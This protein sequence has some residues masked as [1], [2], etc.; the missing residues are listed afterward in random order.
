MEKNYVKINLYNF[1]ITF[2]THLLYCMYSILM[3]I[4]SYEE[5]VMKKTLKYSVMTFV[6]ALLF[7]FVSACNN[8]NA[9]T[10]AAANNN[11]VVKASYDR[12]AVE[13]TK[14]DFTLAQSKVKEK[15]G[16]DKETCFSCHTGV[17]ELHT[18]GVHK[19]LDCTNCHFDITK[20]HT[21]NPTPENRPKVNMNW[22]ACGQCHDN[23]MHSFLQVGQHRPARFEKSNFNGRSPNPAWD[24]LM[25]PYGFTK[26][27]AA[28]RSHSVMLIDQFVVDRAF[29]GQFQPKDGWNYIFES[30]PVWDVLYDAKEKDPNFK[31]LP[32]TARAVNPVCMNCKTMDHM[33]DWAYLGEPN[34]KAKWSRLSDPVEMAKNMNHALNCTFCHDPHSAEPRIVRDALIEAMTSEAPY[35]KNNLYQTDPN[36]VKAEVRVIDTRSMMDDTEPKMIRKIAILPKDDPRRQTLQCAQCHVEYNCA[37]GT[38]LETGAEIG[39]NDPRTN[40]FPLKNALALYDHYFVNLKFGD[41]KNK[42]SGAYL[43]KAQHPE[44][45]TYYNSIHDKA[46]VSCVQCHMEVV[47]KDGKLQYTS[48]FVQSPRFILDATCLT[49]DCHGT[50]AEKHK[51]WQGKDPEYV[52]VSTNWTPEDAKYS[53]DSIKI[54]TTGKMRKAEFWLAELIDAIATAERL[55]VDKATIDKAREQHS[56]AHILWE[57]WTAENSDGFHNPALARESLTQSITE[58]MKGYD[59][60]DAAMKK[61]AAK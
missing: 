44:F 1:Y 15:S 57:Y 2:A 27:H 47:E 10:Q 58:S 38:N 25:A 12:S 5:D 3:K 26:E 52:K 51:N 41:F 20:E 7:V 60:L 36:H 4:I 54:Y 32:Q 9:N 59:M 11:D 14:A 6:T 53:I 31:D 18:R 45:E 49:S 8:T 42:F 29:G 48:H 35:A 46:G 55:G 40:H 19:D 56:K 17:S 50:G 43:W 28:T 33:L 39:F 21:E 13:A 22:E 37:K 16:T 34:P 61:M 30:G 23:Q 24:K